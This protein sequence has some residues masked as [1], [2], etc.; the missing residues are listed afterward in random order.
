MSLERGFLVSLK[1]MDMVETMNSNSISMYIY[2]IKGFSYSSP[3]IIVE[4][5]V[6]HELHSS[7]KHGPS[8]GSVI[9][10]C[11]LEFGLG[12]FNYNSRVDGVIVG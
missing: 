1:E 6:H 5:P 4:S 2:F 9:H 10:N 11:H 8:L 3:V 7:I 12:I